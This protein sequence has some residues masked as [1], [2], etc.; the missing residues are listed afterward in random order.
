M[1]PEKKEKRN[2]RESVKY[3]ALQ[4]FC[5]VFI[6]SIKRLFFINDPDFKHWID[7]VSPHASHILPA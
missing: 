5:V 6:Y 3:L 1:I 7:A 4:F 2:I